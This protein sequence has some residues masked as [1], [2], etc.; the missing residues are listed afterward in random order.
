MART[1]NVGGGLGDD[2]RRP[3]PAEPQLAQE[4]QE[5]QETKPA[6]QLRRSSRTSATV[7]PRPITQRRGSRP[8]PRPQGL[9]LVVHL[10]LRAATARQVHQ[11]RFV[12]FDVWF[13]L[14][15]DERAAEGFY[16]PL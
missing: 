1:K 3:P 9:P 10:D 4:T 14:R 6:P 7:P 16:T 5:S 8:P 15:R 12:E 11:L 2:D 13:P